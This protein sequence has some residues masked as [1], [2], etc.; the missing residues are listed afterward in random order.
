MSGEQETYILGERYGKLAVIIIFDRKK[1]DDKVLF[2]DA[3]QDYQEGKS[4][5]RLRPQDIEKIVK[6]FLNRRT[7]SKYAHLASFD[8]IKENEFNLNISR[9]VDTFDE[10]EEIDIK[11]VEAEIEQLETDLVKVRAQMKKY[12]KELGL[13]G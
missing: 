13:N 9:Y 11:A 3:S 2:I 5:N 7:V 8:E 1:R 6:A 4:Q 12:L 10:E